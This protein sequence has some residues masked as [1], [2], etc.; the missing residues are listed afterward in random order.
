MSDV[1]IPI[2]GGGGTSSDDVTATRKNIL[3]GKTAITNDS[4]DEVV[5]GT[6]PD[7]GAKTAELACGESYTIP[8]GYHNGSGKVT[9]KSLASQTSANAG[10]GDI[11]TGK[12]AYVNGSKVTGTMANQGAKTAALNCG[13]SYTIPAGYHNGSG[14]VAA[15]SLASQTGVQSGKTAISAGVVRSGYEGWVNGSRVTGNM[16]NYTGNA[17]RKTITPSTAQQTWKIPAGYHDGNGYVAVNAVGMGSAKTIWGSYFYAS[18]SNAAKNAYMMTGNGMS[19]NGTDGFKILTAGTYDIEVAHSNTSGNPVLT[20]YKN[21]AQ[22]DKTTDANWAKT[23]SLA[24]GDIIKVHDSSGRGL[25]V[26]IFKK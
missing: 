18:S 22:I 7:Q 13:G 5:E 9:A 6:M 17:N 21:D 24:A 23:I 10:A 19:A 26:L 25:N 8:E 1:R 3:Q 16:T 11:L 2:D 4:D 20:I 12:T 14:K 15:N